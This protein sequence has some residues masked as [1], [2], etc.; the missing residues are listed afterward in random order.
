MRVWPS[1]RAVAFQATHT[2]S[3][4]V[5]RSIL[6]LLFFLL[7]ASAQQDPHILSAVAYLSHHVPAWER[8]NHCF[9]CHNNGDG[10]RAL[11]AARRQGYSVAPALLVS[12]PWNYGANNRPDSDPKLARLH[13]AVAARDAQALTALQDP[14][15]SW[16]I[17]TGDLP[18][19]P[20]TWGTPLATGL[21]HQITKSNAAYT[22]LRNLKPHFTVD[23]AAR[24]WATGELKDL[25]ALQSPSG[26]WGTTRSSPA[27]VFDTAVAI[28]A[29]AAHPNPPQD[30]L[31]RARA[32]LRREQLSTGAWPE[33]TR[34]SGGNSYAHHIST[35]AWAT[36]ALLRLEEIRLAS[37]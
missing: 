32:Y 28:L 30:A 23:H 19:S 17:L 25:L 18:G 26:A 36:L 10:L 9:S 12:P 5:T 3:I 35:T 24:A 16:S 8:D 7:P 31:T 27:E 20:I 29:L 1:G 2:G 15:G 21:A 13:F 6:A 37:Q 33:T 34:P 11:L 4:P 22:W 14:N